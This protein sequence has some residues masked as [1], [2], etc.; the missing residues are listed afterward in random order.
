[1]LK[2]AFGNRIYFGNCIGKVNEKFVLCMT[3]LKKICSMCLKYV[4]ILY[5]RLA[6]KINPKNIALD[7]KCL[8]FGT[9]VIWHILLVT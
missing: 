1:M 9:L 2:I 5:L 4:K 7:F 6:I 8:F 3:R